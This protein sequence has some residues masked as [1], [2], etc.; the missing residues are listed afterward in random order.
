[1][2]DEKCKHEGYS[3][4]VWSRSMVRCKFKASTEAGYCKKHDPERIKAKRDAKHAKWKTESDERA[5]RNRINAK[6]SEAL[7]VVKAIASGVEY[8]VGTAQ[9]FMVEL[10]KV[11]K[12]EME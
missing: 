7:E 12:G 9:A 5:H 6:E 2:I 8:P 1:M 10:D 11:I 3:G 4:D